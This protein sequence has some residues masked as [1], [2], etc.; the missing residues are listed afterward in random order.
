MRSLERS[1]RLLR[2]PLLAR[3]LLLA[4][5]VVLSGCDVDPEPDA[6]DTIVAAQVVLS[7][8][9]SGEVLERFCTHTIPEIHVTAGQRVKLQVNYEEV[10]REES[11]TQEPCNPEDDISRSPR[12]RVIALHCFSGL[13][14]FSPAELISIDTSPA[15]APVDGDF[16]EA[17]GYEYV[18]E[19]KGNGGVF[20][21]L[22]PECGY[23]ADDE[24]W[25]ARFLAPGEDAGP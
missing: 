2:A 25:I 10:V 4:L 23:E 13:D 6:T 24:S 16:A 7:D 21:R 1:L 18:L 17:S 5:P 22:T 9:D 19:V 12:E 8:A 3:V 11:I 15:N 14:E 20:L